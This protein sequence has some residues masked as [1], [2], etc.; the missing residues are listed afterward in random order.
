MTAEQTDEDDSAGNIPLA[1]GLSHSLMQDIFDIHRVFRF[2]NYHFDEYTE[3]QY[4]ADIKS[5]PG[6]DYLSRNHKF[7]A[8]FNL[9]PQYIIHDDMFEIFKYVFSA[10]EYAQGL[11]AE[12]HD[13][14][15]QLRS[16]V[17]PRAIKSVDDESDV[18]HH[19]FD[20]LDDYLFE[21]AGDA[22]DKIILK[23]QSD[24][25]INKWLS[26]LH[27]RDESSTTLVII[28]RRRLHC[29]HDIM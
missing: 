13:E 20:R 28:D 2:S 25:V 14:N 6:S 24:R 19:N 17:I 15:R 9:H 10:S 26:S 3:E 8:G 18:F 21:T 22:F 12:L 5:G 7:S 29:Q 4:L 23:T 1:D 16:V 27:C 11:Q